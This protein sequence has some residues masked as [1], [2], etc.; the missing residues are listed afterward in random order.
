MRNVYARDGGEA[1]GKQT[2]PGGGGTRAGDVH[3]MV[4]APKVRTEMSVNESRYACKSDTAYWIWRRRRRRRSKRMRTAD[5]N[6]HCSP[7]DR[8]D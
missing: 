7:A 6:E 8:C 1:G 3:D 4:A 2:Q 5:I